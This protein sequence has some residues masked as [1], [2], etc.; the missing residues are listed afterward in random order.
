[1]SVSRDTV[2]VLFACI[3]L[4]G[5]RAMEGVCPCLSASC[6]ACLVVTQSILPSAIRVRV[7]AAMIILLAL[8]RSPFYANGTLLHSI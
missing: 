4:R 7:T 5:L 3:E 2:T 1:M 8:P 6:H